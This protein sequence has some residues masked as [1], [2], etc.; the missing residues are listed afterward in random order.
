MQ[1]AEEEALKLK[2]MYILQED[3]IGLLE[4]I[5]KEQEKTI[6]FL[7][8]KL[9]IHQNCTDKNVESIKNFQRVVNNNKVK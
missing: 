8:D 7:K 5:I 2:K 1:I 6:Q 4:Q 3:K 9:K